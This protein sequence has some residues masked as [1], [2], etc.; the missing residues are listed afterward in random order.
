MKR[1]RF[2]KFAKMGMRCWK[3][4]ATGKKSTEE[5]KGGGGGGGGGVG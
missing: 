2:E 5:G 3:T 4:F 1:A